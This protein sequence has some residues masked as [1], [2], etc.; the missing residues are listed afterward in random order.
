MKY[1]AALNNFMM[2]FFELFNV[3]HYPDNYILELL[4]YLK[5]ALEEDS[6]SYLK[7][8]T[9]VINVIASIYIYYPEIYSENFENELL[10]VLSCHFEPS[11]RIDDNDNYYI[12]TL[13][14][15]SWICNYGDYLDQQAQQCDEI[16]DE[17]YY[18][19]LFSLLFYDG[20]Y[21]YDS[22][23]CPHDDALKRL[24]NVVFSREIARSKFVL[25]LQS[26]EASDP[27][28]IHGLVNNINN[29]IKE[30]SQKAMSNQNGQ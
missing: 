3:I 30:N 11:V 28:V 2:F 25:F 29:I 12:V 15:A 9:N 22:L 5:G 10:F 17:S 24:I 4:N 6:F 1:R 21:I 26:Y 27:D 19:Q 7:N 16:N 23:S 13:L 14:I 20:A 18:Y 8:Y